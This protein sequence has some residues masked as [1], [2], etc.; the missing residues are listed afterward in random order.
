MIS[1][2]MEPKAP[3]WLTQ[4][5]DMLKAIGATPV[6]ESED[7]GSQYA[8]QTGEIGLE[9]LRLFL[10]EPE[11]AIESI[12]GYLKRFGDAN[13]QAGILSRTTPEQFGMI[14]SIASLHYTTSDTEHLGAIHEQIAEYLSSRN[15][16]NIPY[17]TAEIR[18][19]E[20][21]RD[22]V[23]HWSTLTW[24]STDGYSSF[25]KDKT[26]WKSVQQHIGLPANNPVMF[27]LAI[28]RNATDP[29][30]RHQFR[31]SYPD[32]TQQG[33]DII[34]A[35]LFNRGAHDEML[36]DKMS[37]YKTWEDSMHDTLG[38]Y[39]VEYR[40]PIVRSITEAKWNLFP[41]KGFA[42]PGIVEKMART[43]FAVNQEGRLVRNSH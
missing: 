21:V 43:S 2:E 6:T 22:L 30:I 16:S 15:S 5:Y 1:G 31:E 14:T 25:L 10:T 19:P 13:K 28:P 37:W 42:F 17:L 12:G 39:G 24:P 11:Q 38:R 32:L 36:H 41:G 33:I 26:H 3:A 35:R 23:A 34:A 40:A 18:T 7:A 27:A 8:K 4:G 29:G 20:L 9:Y